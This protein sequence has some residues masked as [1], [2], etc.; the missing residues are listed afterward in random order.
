[1]GCHWPSETSLWLQAANVVRQRRNGQPGLVRLFR[2]RSTR[3]AQH[4]RRD[5]LAPGRSVHP[6]C[7]T[8]WLLSIEIGLLSIKLRRFAP[9]DAVR[10]SIRRAPVLVR[11]PAISMG[12]ERALRSQRSPTMNC[13]S[14][15]LRAGPSLATLGLCA[16]HSPVEHSCTLGGRWRGLKIRVRRASSPCRRLR[17]L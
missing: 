9:A 4:P 17:L 12:A 5:K 3:R 15:S 2:R 6:S 11:S 14:S 13:D 10:C 16:N 8:S 7:P 1:M